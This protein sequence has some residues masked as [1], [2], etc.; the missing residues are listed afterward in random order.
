MALVDLLKSM[1]G[2]TVPK[3][4]ID[5]AKKRKAEEDEEANKLRDNNNKKDKTKED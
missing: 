4:I 1:G 5:L 3:E 2:V